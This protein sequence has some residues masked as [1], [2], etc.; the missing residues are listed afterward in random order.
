MRPL[1]VQNAASRAWS[2]GSSTKSWVSWLCRKR[3]ASSPW[4]RIT[5][6]CERALRPSRAGD[7][8]PLSWPLQFFRVFRD[9]GALAQDGIPA[10]RAG[11]AGVR[12]R[13]VVVDQPA[14]APAGRQRRPL[15]GARHAAALG[16]AGR[17]R[18]RRRGRPRPA[19]RLVPHLR[20]GQEDQGRQLRAG[21]RHHAAPAAVQAGA[22][23]GKPARRHPGR[24]L[25]LPP[26]ARGAG[27]GRGPEA[28]HR[29]PG[30]RGRDGAAGA[31]GPASG[32]AFLS[33]HLRLLARQ[34]RVAPAAAGDA[35]H[36]QAAGSRLVAAGT[37]NGGEDAGGSADPGQH[38]GKGNRPRRRPAAGFGRLQQP[39]ARRD[40]AADRPDRD[41]W[42][43]R[44]PSR[45]TCARSTCRPTPPGTPTPGRACRRRPSPCRAR[46]RCWRRCSRRRARRCTSSSRGD[47]SSQ[48]SESLDEHN[49]AVNKYQRGR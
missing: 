41:L 7:I 39:A 46:P 2:G 48:F 42:H 4:A 20:A 35:R 49:R 37:A 32:G 25:D 12:R 47:G 28:R 44:P 43:G 29:R 17:P 40:A 5:P 23:R 9:S 31:R 8:A 15:G 19:V 22:R 45:A 13:R 27:Q 14:A 18:C 26:D 6:R 16:G 24:G 38:R 10:R 36:G 3:A 1:G 30:R 34:H 11:S 33:G 21:N